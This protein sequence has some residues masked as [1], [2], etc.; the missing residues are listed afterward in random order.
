MRL[1]SYMDSKQ[2]KKAA[3][4]IIRRRRQLG[5][6]NDVRLFINNYCISPSAYVG[7]VAPPLS[8]DRGMSANA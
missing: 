6:V 7:G 5:C 1:A 2:S 4:V 3:T 8:I